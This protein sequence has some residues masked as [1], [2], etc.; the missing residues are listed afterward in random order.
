MADPTVMSQLREACDYHIPHGGMSDELDL[1]ETLI[2]RVA[3]LNRDAGEIGPGMLA[4][5]VADARAI[6]GEPT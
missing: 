4:S 5:L 3:S 2:R 1:I 6:V